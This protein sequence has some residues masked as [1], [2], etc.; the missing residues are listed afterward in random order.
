MFRKIFRWITSLDEKLSCGVKKI[1]ISQ[2]VEVSTHWPTGQKRARS[3]AGIMPF[4][5][6]DASSSPAHSLFVPNALKIPVN[7]VSI[8]SKHGD[9]WSWVAWKPLINAFFPVAWPNR[10]TE[11]RNPPPQ[12]VP[13]PFFSLFFTF[14]YWSQACHADDHFS[15]P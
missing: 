1:T 13:C 2:G 11:N 14:P 7:D 4:I 15:Q 3:L 9:Y 8:P 5:C 6:I 10:K 12:Q